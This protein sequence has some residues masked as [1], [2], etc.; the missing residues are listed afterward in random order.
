M[1]DRIQG[2]VGAS[3]IVIDKFHSKALASCKPPELSDFR[4]FIRSI[5]AISGKGQTHIIVAH[6]NT[7]ES[8]KNTQFFADPPLGKGLYIFI[9]DTP[10]T[11]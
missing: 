11:A 10:R 3:G 5:P 4:H 6:N 9:C 1:V 8:V 2:D 7:T